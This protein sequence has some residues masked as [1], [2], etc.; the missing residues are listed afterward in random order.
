MK[1][2]KVI[3]REI[4]DSRGFPTVECELILDN[5]F[6]VVASAPSGASRGKY[7]AV[8]LYDNNTR[9]MGFGVRKAVNNIEQIIAPLLIG[10]EPNTVQMDTMLVQLDGTDNKSKLGANALIA[11][12]MAICKAHALMEHIELYELIA[13][14]CGFETVSL[15]LPMFNMI[16]GGVHADNNLQIQEYMIVIIGMNSFREV[17][18]CGVTIFHT[19]KELLRQQGKRVAVGDEGGFAPNFTNETEALDSLMMAIE[20]VQKNFNA[21]IMISLDVAASQLYDAKR[22]MYCWQGQYI[23]TNELIA[24]YESLLKR[25]PIYSIEDGLSESDWD[26]WQ[27]LSNTI[28][29]KVKIVGDD[30]FVTNPQRIWEGIQRDI[31]NAVLIKPNQI[32]TVTETL[33]AVKLCKEYN[34]HTI[35]SH[36]SGETNDS[37]IADFA[38]GISADQ[39]KAGGCSRG[40]RMAKYNRLLRIEQQLILF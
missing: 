19:L 20:L 17:M 38:V 6:S 22:Q 39:I 33:Q 8:S 2:T 12:S 21:T 14:L 32:G 36:R 34:I 28:G 7:E 10:K 30:I 18:E 29:S 31:S 13:Y 16:N 26:G 23:N 24:W 37:F 11:T 27:T 3:S 9:L 15:P 5:N 35:I 1:I 4:F 40:E 25:Y